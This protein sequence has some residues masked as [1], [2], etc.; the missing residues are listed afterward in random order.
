MIIDYSGAT[1]LDNVL[2]MLQ[3]GFGNGA[4]NGLGINSATAATGTFAGRTGLGYAEATDLFTTFPA[5]FS[6]QQVDNTAILIKFTFYG[7]ANL[8]GSTNLND[9]NVLAGNFGQTGRR[10][11]RGD[12]DYNLTINL[13]DF[14][15][16]AAGF[17][18]SGL[19]PDG[20]FTG[21]APATSRVA[22][23]LFDGDEEQ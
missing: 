22:D 16:L 2:F 4:W 6:G 10:W 7:D 3:R 9:F 13:A 8:D 15:R 20:A 19:A 5:T 18:G 12:N 1:Q 17:G 14:N 21:K 11:V 23:E